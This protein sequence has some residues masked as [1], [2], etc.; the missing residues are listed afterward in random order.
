M[1][2]F[3]FVIG[4]IMAVAGWFLLA[5]DDE[6]CIKEYYFDSETLG[7]GMCF[8]GGILAVLML[9]GNGIMWLGSTGV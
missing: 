8:I 2:W 9:F 4:L 7:M 6:I 5:Y 1:L 3:W